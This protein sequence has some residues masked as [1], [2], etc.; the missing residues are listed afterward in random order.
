MQH[1]YF[2]LSSEASYPPPV[3]LEGS[4]KHRTFTDFP[5]QRNTI[6]KTEDIYLAVYHPH[7]PLF[8]SLEGRKQHSLFP[9]SYI[10]LLYVILHLSISLSI[11]LSFFT[12]FSIV[13]LP[14]MFVLHLSLASSISLISCTSFCITFTSL[15]PFSP[16]SARPLLPTV[17]LHFSGA[18]LLSLLFLAY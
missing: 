3:P 18:L 7:L 8:R 9:I 5:Q 12:S 15:Y 2:V 4:V 16:F 13:L 1:H 14:S 6:P 11:F 17:V 10:S